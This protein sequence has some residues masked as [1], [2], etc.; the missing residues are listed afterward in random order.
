M[1]DACDRARFLLEADA[2]PGSSKCSGL[3][4]FNA[5]ERPSFSSAASNSFAIPLLLI[6][7]IN[8]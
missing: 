4:N 2:H 6:A 1:I 8:R 7:R 5:T 3:I